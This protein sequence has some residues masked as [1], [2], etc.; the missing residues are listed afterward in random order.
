MA[1]TPL[2]LTVEIDGVP[3]GSSIISGPFQVL[4]EIQDGARVRTAAPR[5]TR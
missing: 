5:D 1:A 4:R 2:G 3:E